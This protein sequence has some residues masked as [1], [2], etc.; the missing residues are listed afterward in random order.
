MPHEDEIVVRVAPRW[1]W[2]II[3]E[4]LAMD[5]NSKAFG[6]ELRDQISDAYDAMILACE[7]EINAD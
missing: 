3:D 6:R 7:E 5:A 1:A 2:E 4:T